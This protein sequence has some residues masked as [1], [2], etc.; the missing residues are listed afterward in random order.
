MASYTQMIK[1]FAKRSSNLHATTHFHQLLEKKAHH[2]EGCL[3]SA[4][5]TKFGPKRE[6]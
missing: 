6:R 1:G 2:E 3:R 4:N 5:I